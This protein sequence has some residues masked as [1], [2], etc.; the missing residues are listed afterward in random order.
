MPSANA[1]GIVRGGVNLGNGVRDSAITPP[2]LA[3]LGDPPPP[4]EGGSPRHAHGQT[5]DSSLVEIC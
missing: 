3:S 4:G 2:R 5:D 1:R